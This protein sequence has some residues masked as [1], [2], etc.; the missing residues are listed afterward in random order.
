MHAG[1]LEV[2]TARPA[3]LGCAACEALGRLL[4][5]EERERATKLRFEDDRRAFVVAHG[6]RRMALGLALAV[7]PADLRFGTGAHGEPLLVSP[8]GRTP[9]F[10]LTR[11]RE[12]V[13][14]ALSGDG[15]VGIDVEPVRDGVDASLLERYMDAG[16]P[17]VDD[18]D[19]YARWTALEA[20]WK[21]R[22]LGLSGSHPRIA[23]QP[24]ETGA[25]DVLFGVDGQAAGAV[26]MRLP[27][28]DTHVLSLACDSVQPVRLVE[29]EALAAA[30]RTEP[31]KAL[32]SCKNGNCFE[33]AAPNI[34]SS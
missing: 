20:F 8:A 4:D 15:A 18:E 28:P 3:A 17:L 16:E 6:M 23:L 30:P 29:F 34:F 9:A 26:V 14:F 25:L 7:D 27:A 31:H 19:F 2:W 32:S 5:A 13:A 21:A 11:S 1:G 12:F 24:N 33:A 22:G 10:S